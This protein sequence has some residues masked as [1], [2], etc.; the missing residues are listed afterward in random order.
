MKVIFIKIYGIEG[1]KVH[2]SVVSGTPLGLSHATVI[3]QT[4]E[5]FIRGPAGPHGSQ[6]SRE[7]PNIQSAVLTKTMWAPRCNFHLRLTLELKSP[8]G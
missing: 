7:H 2:V 3:S 6:R 4:S 1:K 8:S 5:R